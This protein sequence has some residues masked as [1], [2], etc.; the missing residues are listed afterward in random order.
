ML[1]LGGLCE[2][3]ENASAEK[4][5]LFFWAKVALKS[6]DKLAHISSYK[7]RSTRLPPGAATYSPWYLPSEP[8]ALMSLV[9][10][11]AAMCLLL[12]DAFRN[13]RNSGELVS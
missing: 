1:L 12:E 13:D 4:K 11:T 6:Y 2:C 3:G 8:F 10:P 9:P 7:T 5:T